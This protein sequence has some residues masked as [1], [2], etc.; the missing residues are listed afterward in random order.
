M[1]DLDFE[2]RL[3]EALHRSAAAVD[4]A[5]VDLAAVRASAA[6][7]RRARRVRVAA[8]AGA[9]AVA[10]SVAAVVALAVDDPDRTDTGPAATATTTTT[11]RRPAPTTATSTPPD[12]TAGSTAPPDDQPATTDETPPDTPVEGTGTTAAT[13]TTPTTAAPAL[14]PEAVVSQGSRTWAVYIA[15]VPPG[16]YDD[17][18]IAGAHAA[19]AALG[20]SSGPGASNLACDQGAPEALGLPG[21]SLAVALYFATE[22]DAARVRRAFED[23][24]DPV[25]GVVPVTMFC[26]D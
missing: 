15:V 20:Y 22:A 23:R 9:L 3:T 8:S 12:R 24:G 26:L 1:S 11:G 4:G 25:V 17:P 18:A 7:R 5:G 19:T 2:S 14:P 16:A 13:A 21:D 6:R 10:A